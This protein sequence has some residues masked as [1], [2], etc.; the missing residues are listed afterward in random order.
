MC[1][2][3]PGKII[4]IDENGDSPRMACVSFG[5]VIKSVCIDWLPDS[6]M[7]DYVMVHVGFALSKVDEKEAEE[8]L[9]IINEMEK[10]I[11]NRMADNE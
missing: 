6:K 7:G 8:S 11:V 9:R 1:L 3:I 5:G 4:S 10:Q 2:A